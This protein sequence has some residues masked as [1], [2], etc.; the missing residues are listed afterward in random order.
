MMSFQTGSSFLS[1]F[2][3]A[4]SASQ[5]KPSYFAVW[6]AIDPFPTMDRI[7]QESQNPGSIL[8]HAGIAI[9]TIE[10]NRYHVGIIYKSGN[11]WRMLHQAWYRLTLDT[12]IPSN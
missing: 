2:G 3:N 5:E 7:I 4:W 10:P 6:Q 11:E 12:P 1:A 8:K 9:R